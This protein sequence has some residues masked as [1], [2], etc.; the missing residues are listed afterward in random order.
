MITEVRIHLD[1]HRPRRPRAVAACVGIAA[2]CLP[3]PIRTHAAP[4][5][6][7]FAVNPCPANPIAHTARQ[8]K[9]SKHKRRNTHTKHHPRKR[10]HHST[11]SPTP[12]WLTLPG[13][14]IGYNEDAILT[15]DSYVHGD[16]GGGPIYHVVGTRAGLPIA[17]NDVAGLPAGTSAEGFPPFLTQPQPEHPRGLVVLPLRVKTPPSG[18]NPEMNRGYFSVFDATT[19]AHLITS[20]P[21][22]EAALFNTPVAY[23]NGSLRLAGCGGYTT[24]TPAGAVSEVSFLP[25]SPDTGPSC[26]A[27]AV[28]DNEILVYSPN[29]ECEAVYVSNVVTQSIV[30]QSPC[31]PSE[32]RSPSDITSV[33]LPGSGDWF[34]NGTAYGAQF[35]RGIFSAATGSPFEPEGELALEKFDILAGVR[36]SV[37]LVDA[38]ISDPGVD[39]PSYF[40]S[41]STWQ[42]VFTATNA[43]R[44][45]AFGLADN[46]AWV[47]GAAGRIVINALTGSTVASHWNVLPEA[48]GAGWTLAGESTG[49]CCSSEYLLRSKGTMLASLRI[50]P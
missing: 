41:T 34:F 15:E 11:R 6:T 19:G 36:S 17:I 10:E 40:V 28:V 9:N 31:L 45:R 39:G 8:H 24:I 3:S 5:C 14:V 7:K 1:K 18:I 35:A 30:S 43:Q 29:E 12:Q 44:F 38:S 4:A 26:A 37:V 27:S 46:D 13:T 16:N 42:P 50:A 2:L 23:I 48:G 32:D 33:P 20:A 25:G 49:A 21:F 47:E 22:S